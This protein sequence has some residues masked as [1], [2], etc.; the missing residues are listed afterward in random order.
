VPPTQTTAP[1]ATF[2]S[3]AEYADATIANGQSISGTL[4][5]WKKSLVGILLPATWTAAGLSFLAS[6]DGV[7]FGK[8]YDAFGELTIVSL[9]GGE[10]VT[11]DPA[12]FFGVR[13]V[14]IRSGTA[15]T[16]VN[17]GGSRVLRAVLRAV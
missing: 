7:T 11:L 16:P 10:Y 2:V 6:P 9:A 3:D 5:L 4:D 15:G 12:K 17:Q 8:L 14:Q 1:D 13:Y